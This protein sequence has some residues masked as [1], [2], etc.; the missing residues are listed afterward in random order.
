MVDFRPFHNTDPPHLLK[1]WHAANLGP[2]AAEGFPCDVLELA[3]YSRPYFDRKG[4]ILAVDGQLF[5]ATAEQL[6]VLGK[7]VDTPVNE[8][9]EIQLDLGRARHG[10]KFA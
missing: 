3:V 6:T 1:L 9:L 4:L 7:M 2:S 8:N 5:T 10:G